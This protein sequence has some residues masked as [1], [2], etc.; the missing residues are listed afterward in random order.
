[1]IGSLSTVLFAFKGFC[2]CWPILFWILQSHIVSFTF[3][4]WCTLPGYL[5]GDSWARVEEGICRKSFSLLYLSH[6]LK[7]TTERCLEGRGCLQKFRPIYLF[8]NPVARKVL[9]LVFA[10]TFVS[11]ALPGQCVR[12]ALWAALSVCRSVWQRFIHGLNDNPKAIPEICDPWDRWHGISNQL[13]YRQ[14]IKRV[15]QFK[16]TT[17][18]EKRQT[19]Y[20]IGFTLQ[21]ILIQWNYENRRSI[22][23]MCVQELSDEKEEE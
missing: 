12:T 16:W 23:Y 14:F 17:G 6:F 2:L 7:L 3:G 20:K 22:S 19:G 15:S 9:V 5:A 4:I 21:S 11:S 8:I 13:S 10:F 1:M 18:P